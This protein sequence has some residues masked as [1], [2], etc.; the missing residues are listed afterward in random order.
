MSRQ[1]VLALNSASRNITLSCLLALAVAPP[2]FAG[3]ED[4]DDPELC[5]CEY[6]G[7]VYDIGES[8]PAGDGCNVCTCTADGEVVCTLVACDEVDCWYN[9]AGY[10]AGQQFPA[11]DDCNVCTCNADGTVSC[12][13]EVCVDCYYQGTA[14]SAGDTF[15]AGDGCNTCVCTSDGGVMCTEVAC[16]DPAAEPWRDYHYTDV[17]TC[18]QVTIL[19]PPPTRRFDSPCGCGCEDKTLAP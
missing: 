4:Q 6:G 7:Q 10:Q 3:C 2:L 11:G 15:P 9:G 16:C 14:Y 5:T 19:C 12:T 1:G 18:A 8:F 13:D 17:A